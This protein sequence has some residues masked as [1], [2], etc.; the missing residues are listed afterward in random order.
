MKCTFTD[1]CFSCIG[2]MILSFVQIRPFLS[3]LSS[4]FSSQN[5]RAWFS[6]DSKCEIIENRK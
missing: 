2:V 5:L 3:R 4:G 1:I 6:H